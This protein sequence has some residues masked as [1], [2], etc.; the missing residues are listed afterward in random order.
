MLVYIFS[1]Y[2]GGAL[3]STLFFSVNKKFKV[4]ETLAVMSNDSLL[5]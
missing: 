3:I 2:L 4:Y 1:N 5:F